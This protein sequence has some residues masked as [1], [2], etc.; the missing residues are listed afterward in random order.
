MR[1]L[2][3]SITLI[4]F[5]SC[6]S[7]SGFSQDRV[8]PNLSLRISA[9]NNISTQHFF[10]NETFLNIPGTS[11]ITVGLSTNLLPKGSKSLFI[12]IEMQA[13]NYYPTLNEKSNLGFVSLLVGKTNR[14][15]LSQ[16]LYLKQTNG[17]SFNSLIDETS[18][19]L[20]TTTYS[21]NPFKN[22]NIGAFSNLQVLF[23]GEKR[24]NRNVDYGLGI[25]F[26]CKGAQIFKDRTYPYYLA[27]NYFIQYGLNFN[28]N[29]NF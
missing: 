22:I 21:G 6:S 8:P 7:I 20:N 29:Y 27:N 11:F 2:L 9:G 13:I 14:F 1:L 23:A 5:F 25:D 19:N 17:L 28:M 10:T 4:C 3:A 15:D 16:Q 26:A 12:G 18:S 24:K